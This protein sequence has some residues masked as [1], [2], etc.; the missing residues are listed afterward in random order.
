[1]YR[2]EKGE[3]CNLAKGD[4]VLSQI[5]GENMRKMCM[6]GNSLGC[7]A[8]SLSLPLSSPHFFHLSEMY[9]LS[10]ND[11][12]LVNVTSWLVLQN[13]RP[14]VGSLHFLG[15][16]L[17]GISAAFVTSRLF[18]VVFLKALPFSKLWPIF[19]CQICPKRSTVA[20][21]YFKRPGK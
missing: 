4:P 2:R 11:K 1:M 15:V 19:S 16:L 17:C 12:P 14:T 7:L 13:S 20:F 10:L 3:H 21:Y 8:W 5:L 6:V 18:F 9:T